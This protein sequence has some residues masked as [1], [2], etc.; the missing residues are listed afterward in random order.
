[1]TTY[2]IGSGVIILSWETGAVY[3]SIWTYHLSS[4]VPRG[5]KPIFHSKLGSRWLPIANEISTNNMKC[6][7]PMQ[8]L[9]T[10]RNL[11]SIGSRWRFVLGVTQILCFALEV[12]QILAFLDTNM[13]ADFH[14]GGL[15]QC[16]NASSFVLQGNLGL[17][18]LD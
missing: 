13:L 3:L 10:Q 18:P 16:P 17:N 9:G 5:V 12:T 8:T 4:V 14:V 15:T 2:N 11:Y 1:M 7:W 6:T